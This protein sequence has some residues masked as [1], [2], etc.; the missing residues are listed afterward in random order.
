VHRHD[1]LGR[2]TRPDFIAALDV[3]RPSEVGLH[4]IPPGQ[5]WRN[6]YVESFNAR[7]RDECLNTHSFWSLTQARVV[8]S[9]WKHD[10]NHHRRHSSLGYQP[11]ASY[12]ANCTHGHAARL[13]PRLSRDVR[14]DE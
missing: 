7:I 13:A 11:P 5:P 10:Y 1:G 14:H 4:Y 9:D 8:I 3:S 12:A 6:G 2:R